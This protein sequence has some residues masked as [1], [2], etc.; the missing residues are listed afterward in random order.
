MALLHHVHRHAATGSGM[1]G[2]IEQNVQQGALDR[3]GGNADDDRFRRPADVGPHA[4]D[5]ETRRQHFDALLRAGAQIQRFGRGGRRPR[6]GQEFLEH[7]FHAV[8][9]VPHAAGQLGNPRRPGLRAAGGFLFQHLGIQPETGHRIAEVVHDA[10]GQHAGK[11]QVLFL[12]AGPFAPFFAPHHAGHQREAGREAAGDGGQ[13]Q[14]IEGIDR[15]PR[16]P[17]FP[18]HRAAAQAQF[19]RDGFGARIGDRH[20]ERH[21]RDRA[22]ARRQQLPADNHRAAQMHVL[23]IRRGADRIGVFLEQRDAAAADRHVFEVV[24]HFPHGAQLGREIPPGVRR[25][26]FGRR[27]RPQREAHRQPLAA[28]AYGQRR[29]LVHGA[30]MPEPQREK[31]A[32]GQQGDQRDPGPRLPGVRKAFVRL[33][34]HCAAFYRGAPPPQV[35]PVVFAFRCGMFRAS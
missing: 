10:V 5:L 20:R 13:A 4:G 1:L 9:R 16:G 22:G 28:L 24:F 23:R 32:A 31:P 2:G 12:A 29:G 7:L 35:F 25:A 21:H 19:Q 27:G 26:G 8:E 14:A 3:R 30:A 15:A 17:F 33:Q 18:F 11:G 6:Q 34:S